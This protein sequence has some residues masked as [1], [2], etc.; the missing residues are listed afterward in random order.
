M[1][2]RF[3]IMCFLDD[4]KV[5]VQSEMDRWFEFE[6]PA[7]ACPTRGSG[8]HPQVR[9]AIFSLWGEPTAGR[10]LCTISTGGGFPLAEA[11]G[12]GVWAGTCHS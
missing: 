4:R 11:P 8:P 9:D 5:S 12:G 1:L 7:D 2:L 10:Y 6:P 3:Y